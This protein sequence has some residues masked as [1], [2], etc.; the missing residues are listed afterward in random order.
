MSGIRVR[1]LELKE[2]SEWE[3]EIICGGWWTREVISLREGN[4]A[5]GDT[6]FECWESGD[7]EITRYYSGKKWYYGQINQ[8]LWQ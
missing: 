3:E 5:I 6:I 8:N 2:E 7:D 1:N 4:I